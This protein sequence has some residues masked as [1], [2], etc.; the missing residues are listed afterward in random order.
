MTHVGREQKAPALA[1]RTSPATPA[2]RAA[3]VVLAVAVLFFCY[4][5]QSQTAPLSSDG[6]ANV[7][8]A[9]DMLH[10]NPLLRQWWVSDVS[11]YTTELPQY[12][13]VEVLTGLGP[14]VV[15]VAAAMTYTLL[16][17][18]AAV[19][20]RGAARGG[21]G[22]ARALL[23]AGLMLAPQLSVTSILL[24]SPD[25]IGTAV[26]LLAIWLLIDRASPRG[27]PGTPRPFSRRDPFPRTCLGYVPVLVCL[28]FTWTMVADPIVLLTGI[29][30]LM[31][32][33]TGRAFAG[34]LRR[35]GLRAS[36][37]Y[38]L[39]LAGAAAVAGMAGSFAPRVIVALGGFHQ[40]PVGADTDLGQL[41]HGAWVTFQAFLELFGANVFNTSD[42]G[43][44]PVL[45]VV[46]VSLHLAG[47]I[48]AVCALGVGLARIFRFGELIV[49]VFAVAIVLN[50]GAYMISTHAQDLLG[51]REM[52]EVLPLGAVLA[53]RVLGGRVAAW[54]RAA[55]AWFV[56]VLVVLA[57]G[58]LATLGYGAAQP[59][60]PAENETL[61][62]WLLAHR[63]TDGLATYWQAD[64]TTVDSHRQVL[65]SAVV[66]DVRDRLM[67]YQWET[68]DANFDPA[69]HH[70]S[71]VVADGPDALPGMQL[72]AE[73]T[74]GRPQRIYRADGYTIMVYDT[75][76]LA[77]LDRP[78]RT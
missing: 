46:L 14:W 75:N 53:G 37:W 42:F 21:A 13:L 18:L 52:A 31:L 44:R 29:V 77:D 43:A 61:A 24:L 62:S 16:V 19:L 70:A 3:L 2:R 8:Q 28:L 27:L 69:R 22:L 73:L 4:W 66:Q 48:V 72:S 7:L 47:A 30:P 65:L 50:L 39:S 78:G 45:E 68:D 10:G 59:S 26:P 12:M 5:R 71:F 11:F 58:Y 41:R 35:G 36:R 51:A 38:E 64:S 56:P 40:S 33:G 60:V 6:S 20:A 57:A 32:V 34:L 55:K 63:L 54:T 67:P 49:P 74:F 25:H 9:W 23:A 76:L 1:A 17:L 15:H